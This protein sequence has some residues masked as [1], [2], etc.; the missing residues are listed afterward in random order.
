MTAT[1]S[2][3]Q[4]KKTH[5]LHSYNKW[6]KIQLNTDIYT[7]KSLSYSWTLK[8]SWS[9]HF[10]AAT[11]PRQGYDVDLHALMPADKLQF[12]PIPHLDSRWCQIPKILGLEWE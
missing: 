11:S 5:R 7:E 6:I 9:E 1:D 3:Q 8:I 2:S 10:L 12:I 4:K